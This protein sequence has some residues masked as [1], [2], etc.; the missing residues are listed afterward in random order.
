[1]LSHSNVEFAPP[2]ARFVP[3]RAASERGRRAF[4]ELGCAACHP[5]EGLSARAAHPLAELGAHAGRG[6]L[7]ERPD[8]AAPRFDLDAQQRDELR[9]F[10]GDLA[11]LAAPRTDAEQLE[12][13][14]ARLGC[15]ACHVRDGRGGPGEDLRTYFRAA[16][17]V[18]LGNEGRLPPR[19]DRVGSKLHGA[20]MQKVLLEGA[21]ERPYLATRMPQY[22]AAN[23]TGLAELFERV[24]GSPAD[25]QAPEFSAERAEQGRK[26]AGKGGL[27]C[28]QCHVFDGVRSLGIPAVDLAHV[29]ERI[30]PAWFEK[31]LLDPKSLGM[32]TRM[33]IFW[34]AQGVSTARTILDGDPRKQAEALWSYVSLG[35]S[36]PLPDGLVVSD[37][38][39][40]LTPTT[41][42][43]LC[44]VFMKNAS[45]R[46]LLV[47]NPELVHFAFDLENTRM[48]CAWRGRFFNARGTW[49]ARAGGL[50]WPKSDDLLEFER[51]PALA[52][53][54]SAAAPWPEAFGRAAGFQRLG[55]R[56]DPH[57]RPTFRYRLR[58]VEVAESCVP[59][60]RPGAPALRR[61]FDLTSPGPVEL[62]YL[63]ADPRSREPQPVSFSRGTDGVYRAHAEVEV[64]W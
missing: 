38:E 50:E 20:W 15:L 21:A 31:L 23:V 46:T 35:R 40:E 14:L 44:G 17:E 5:L 59:L 19:L 25:M 48:V 27:G 61:V 16:V 34:D 64:N 60:L 9:A 24:D 13:T 55:T 3:D 8:P 11:A 22:G 47:G 10:T 7:S 41:D 30:K 57:R 52:F 49:Y 39:Y 12:A 29:R 58:E 36:M 45:P 1:L 6:C 53:L 18:D 56:Y 26:L 2:P 37:A 63:R 42:A 51:A 54:A 32:N 4:A 28:I 62:L 33:P 43:I